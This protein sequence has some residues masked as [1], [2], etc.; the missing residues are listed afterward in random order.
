MTN[1]T[2][3]EKQIKW[4]EDIINDA[5]GTLDANIARWEQQQA[6][7]IHVFD[8]HVEMAKIAKTKVLATIANCKEAKTIIDNRNKLDGSFIMQVVQ[9][10]VE[11]S[12]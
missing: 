4:A 7:G 10:A 1:L 3:S 6:N 2:G 12:K 8:K 9:K 5:I 11:Q